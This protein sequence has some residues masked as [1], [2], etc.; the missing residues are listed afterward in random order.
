MRFTNK[1]TV[2][3][4]DDDDEEIMFLCLFHESRSLFAM[5][6]YNMIQLDSR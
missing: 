1:T 5:L 3:M 4:V 2:E 6:Q